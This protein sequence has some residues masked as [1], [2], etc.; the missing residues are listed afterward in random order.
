MH[1]CKTHA[2]IALNETHFSHLSLQQATDGLQQQATASAQEAPQDKDII[3]HQGWIQTC[4]PNH[5]WGLCNKPRTSN[6]CT[7]YAATICQCKTADK[8]A[9]TKQQALHSGSMHFSC[10]PPGLL[11]RSFVKISTQ[12]SYVCWLM[13]ATWMDHECWHS[14]CFFCFLH[15]WLTCMHGQSRWRCQEET[16]K[17]MH[18]IPTHFMHV[19]K[20]A[21]VGFLFRFHI[22]WLLFGMFFFLLPFGFLCALC[23]LC[24]FG[25]FSLRRFP[26]P[27]QEFLKT[28]CVIHLNTSQIKNT[29]GWGQ[30]LARTK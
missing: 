30:C 13:R 23:C 21:L 14:L 17:Y 10:A 18:T 11:S 16:F 28:C 1:V 20:L 27:R 19:K 7:I 24:S 25:F 26:R 2:C 8:H 15:P 12:P 22:R 4:L 29:C 6:A 9:C 5:P 3:G